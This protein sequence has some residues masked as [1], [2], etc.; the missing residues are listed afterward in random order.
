MLSSVKKKEATVFCKWISKKNS[1]NIVTTVSLFQDWS[2]QCSDRCI[3]NLDLVLNVPTYKCHCCCLCC[4]C[5]SLLSTPGRLQFMFN[6]IHIPAGEGRCESR[7]GVCT[8]WLSDMTSSNTD[9]MSDAMRQLS[10]NDRNIQVYMSCCA[11]IQYDILFF[12]RY[13]NDILKNIC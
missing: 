13:W 4:C 9:T 7:R 10:L 5:S 8:G 2:D 12:S 1:P 11:V 6:V 3:L